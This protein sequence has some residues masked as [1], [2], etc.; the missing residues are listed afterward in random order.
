MRSQ[1]RSQIKMRG[2]TA[3]ELLWAHNGAT[4]YSTPQKST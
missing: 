2:S 3:R 4:V 1:I